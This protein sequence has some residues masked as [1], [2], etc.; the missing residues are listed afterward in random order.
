MEKKLRKKVGI[1]KQPNKQKDK[2]KQEIKNST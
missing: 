1:I 2:K